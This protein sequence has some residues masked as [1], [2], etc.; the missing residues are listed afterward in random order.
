MRPKDDSLKAFYCQF[1]FYTSVQG[2]LIRTAILEI[3]ELTLKIR[4]GVKEV[5]M[6]C[7]G[8]IGELDCIGWLQPD[9]NLRT[10]DQG[11]RTG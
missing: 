11:Q 8:T 10:S 3:N 9:S 1:C 2:V 7:P 4:K 6:A 5:S